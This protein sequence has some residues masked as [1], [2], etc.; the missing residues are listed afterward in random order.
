M[1][2]LISAVPTNGVCE[3]LFPCLLR[4][5]TVG[6]HA[7]GVMGAGTKPIIKKPQTH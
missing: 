7:G 5:G 6:N 4:L 3:I 1:I 2:S